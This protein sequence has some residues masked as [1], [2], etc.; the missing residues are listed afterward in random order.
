MESFV[1]CLQCEKFTE[2]T[3]IELLLLLY[4]HPKLKIHDKAIKS[5]HCGTE[6]DS[7]THIELE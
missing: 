4:A 2:F 5:I 3:A 1:A 7:K 6:W